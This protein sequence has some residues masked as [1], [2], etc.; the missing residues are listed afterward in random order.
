MEEN[1]LIVT[2]PVRRCIYCKGREVLTIDTIKE[3][4]VDSSLTGTN[5]LICK[6]KRECSRNMNAD[7]TEVSMT[8][9]G[10]K[11]KDLNI[12]RGKDTIVDIKRD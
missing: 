1:K 6:D 11:M 4:V 3:E 2:N 7:K 5:I 12:T 9:K 10:N 8:F